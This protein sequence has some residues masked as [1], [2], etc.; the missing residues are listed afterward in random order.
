MAFGL[1]PFP[2]CHFYLIIY[3][4][5]RIKLFHCMK[6]FLKIFQTFALLLIN[7]RRKRNGTEYKGIRNDDD[8]NG[9]GDLSRP[10]GAKRHA[11]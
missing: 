11:M 1:F 7:K 10:F 3:S 9:G 4:D 6:D 8:K 5:S 2:Y